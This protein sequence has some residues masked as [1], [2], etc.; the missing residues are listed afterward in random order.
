MLLTLSCGPAN[1]GR[2]PICTYLINGNVAFSSNNCDVGRA[3]FVS[4]VG[5][6]VN[7]TT[8]IAKTLTF[9]VAHKLGGHIGLFLYYTSGLV[10]NGTFGLNSVVACHGNGGIRIVGA[11]TRKHLI[12]TSNLVSTDTRGPRLVVSTT[13]LA[14]TTGATLNG[15]CRTLFDFSSTL[16]NHLL[17]DT[18]RRGRPF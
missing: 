1:S 10:D 7:N 5:S 16:T 14:K 13:A 8:A 4:S 2:T 9:T 11:S 3:T 6:S 17:T 12:L 18:T 15:S